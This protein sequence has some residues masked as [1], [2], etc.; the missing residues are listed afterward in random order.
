MRKYC[1]LVLFV[2]LS[3]CL[4]DAFAQITKTVPL[5]GITVQSDFLRDSYYYG[6]KK[7]N[8]AYD[9]TI[10]FMEVGDKEI[11][12]LFQ[13]AKT[14]RTLQAVSSLLPFLYFSYALRNTSALYNLN[15]FYWVFGG[16][17]SINV[18]LGIWGRAN[19]RKAI[20][21]YNELILVNPLP[22]AMNVTP[23]FQGIHLT[24]RYKF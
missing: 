17:L 3:L 11:D 6:T 13:S 16:S 14:M 5:R 2:G 15:S 20:H 9:L 12:R 19:I 23:P 24:W 7:L 21:R 1:L 8:S 22:Q 4:K 18:G 10:P